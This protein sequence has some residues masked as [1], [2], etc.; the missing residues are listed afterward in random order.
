MKEVKSQVSGIVAAIEIAPGGAVD[1][2][3]IIMLIESMKMEIP[4]ESPATGTL[5][6]VLVDEGDSVTEGQTAEFRI[7]PIGSAKRGVANDPAASV[8]HPKHDHRVSI[9]ARSQQPINRSVSGSVLKPH[10]RNVRNLVLLDPLVGI[11]GS[12]P[13]GP[14][15]LVR[16]NR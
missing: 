9:T 16:A 12:N 2:D 7:A 1:A 8:G 4:V 5:A 15:M 14:S 6:D 11:L 10:Q 13:Y 3:Q